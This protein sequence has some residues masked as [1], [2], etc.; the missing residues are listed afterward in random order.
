MKEMGQ[1]FYAHVVFKDD[2]KYKN[3]APIDVV[4]SLPDDYP[5]YF[6]FIADSLTFE[7]NE[8]QILVIDF[9]PN[10]L[11]PK[12][13]ERSPSETPISDIKTF[14]AIPSTIQMIENNLS[15]ANMDF[16]DFADYVGPD[17]VFRGAAGEHGNARLR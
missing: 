12:D 2:P 15:I 13:Y 11:D 4:H 16:E 8:F 10:S 14:R 1:T 9:G 17:G 6:C 5:G 7:S 3:L